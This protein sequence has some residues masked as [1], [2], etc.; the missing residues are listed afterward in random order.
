MLLMVSAVTGQALDF[1]LD[2][3][4][5]PSLLAGGGYHLCWL[6][7]SRAACMSPS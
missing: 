2:L 4:S 6:S 1:L 7:S 5:D 3:P